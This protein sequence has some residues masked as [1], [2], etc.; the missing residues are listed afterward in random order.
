MPGI[1][2]GNKM[3][4]NAF[5]YII[6]LQKSEEFTTIPIE[7]FQNTLINTQ[8][9]Q[10][11]NPLYT[12]SFGY[13]YVDME[14]VL[15]HSG[16]IVVD[17]YVQRYQYYDNYR[18]DLK[19]FYVESQ[20]PSTGSIDTT[21]HIRNGD[22]K[23]LDWY[24]GLD[25]YYKILSEINFNSLDIVA[26]HIDDDVM[27]LSDKYNANVYNSSTIEDFI[28]LSNSKNIIL[29]QSTYAWWAAFLGSPEN[30]YIPVSRKH[31]SKGIWLDKPSI[32]D[33]D[34]VG[35]FKEFTNIIL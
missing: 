33:I 12:S 1:G 7:Y 20:I 27:K 25:S 34:L 3:F 8:Y 10:L 11:K 24:L 18:D 35:G 9:R 23:T 30:V 13:Q 19:R 2:L 14:K 32:D 4:I 29:S 17:S 26:N 21:L 28:F 5:C 22:Y 31:I 15:N 6:S 16:D